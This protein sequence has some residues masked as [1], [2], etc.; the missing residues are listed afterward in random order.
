MQLQWHCSTQTAFLTG[1]CGLQTVQRLSVACCSPPPQGEPPSLHV[2][3]HHWSGSGGPPLLSWTPTCKTVSEIHQITAKTQER[4]EVS[5]SQTDL[6]VSG[7]VPSPVVCDTVLA[8]VVCTNPLGLGT[9]AYLSVRQTNK[10]TSVTLVCFNLQIKAEEAGGE[11]LGA[12]QSPAASVLQASARSLFPAR[13]GIAWPSAHAW[14]CLC[15]AAESGSADT[16][17]LCL[18]RWPKR[19]W[20]PERTEVWQELLV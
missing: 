11:Q 20:A 17:L 8:E 19:K 13:S 18:I 3:R 5:L 10:Q 1:T 15:S 12:A 4:S 16:Q 7:S 14:R 2:P 6:N 9:R